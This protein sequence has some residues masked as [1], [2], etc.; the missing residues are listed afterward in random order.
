M[1][2]ELYKENLILLT[3]LYQLSMSYGYYKNGMK[4]KEAVFNLFY[5]KN[6]FKGNYAICC[7]LST[8]IEFIENF[9]FS[10]S[11]ID[12]LKTLKGNDDKNLFDDD[13]LSYLS[14]LKFTGEIY[15]VEEGRVVF[16]HEPL[17]RIK[18]PI[19][20]GQIIETALLNIV[21]FQTLIATKTSRIAHSTQGDPI[22]EFGLRRAQGIDGSLSASYAAMIGGASATSN[23]LAGKLFDIPVKGTHA[24]SWVMSFLDED[25]AFEKYAHVMPNNCVFL[26]D[27]YNTIEG[28]KKAIIAAKKVKERGHSLVGIR[29]DSGDMAKLSIVARKMLDDSD[30][31]EAQIFASNDLD[32]YTIAKLKSEGARIDVWGVG[33]KLVTA[34]D[35]PALGGVYKLSALRNDESKWEYKIKKSEDLIKVSNPGILQVMRLSKDGKFLADV[36]CNDEFQSS[37][38]FIP[39]DSADEK[40]I[41]KNTHV[42]ELLVPIFKNGK[43]VYGQ[44]TLAD[45]QKRRIADLE[46]LDPNIRENNKSDFVY[47]VGL[48]KELHELKI[49]LLAKM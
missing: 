7:G 41:D 42:E 15:A 16:P 9:H 12:Y 14:Q 3:D 11:D 34:Y 43:R 44:S 31:K 19:I 5:R 20:Q 26:V 18:A 27:T 45:A 32:E 46:K 6:P 33:T 21:N 2:N 35:Q 37:D 29:L 10:T 25:N 17:V 8:V 4:D 1:I 22:L 30:F 48:E 38:K 24:H 39:L 36:I 40:T 13:F 23:V 49:E 28:I 47:P